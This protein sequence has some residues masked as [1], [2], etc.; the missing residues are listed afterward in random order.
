[1]SDEHPEWRGVERKLRTIG[2]RY[3]TRIPRRDSGIGDP[4]PMTAEVVGIWRLP[5]NRTVELSYGWSQ[6]SKCYL[7]GVSTMPDKVYGNA[8]YDFDCVEVT[9]AAIN[10]C[11]PVDKVLSV[12]QARKRA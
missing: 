3:G 11:D 9:M 2:D 10:S 8:C 6:F 1:M 4:N 7:F 5:N 12:T